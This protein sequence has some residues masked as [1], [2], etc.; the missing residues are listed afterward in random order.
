MALYIGTSGWSY[1]HWDGVLYPPGL[2]PGERFACYLQRFHTV[3]V[4][5]PFYRWPHD[6]TFVRWHRQLPPDF[7]M[8]VKAA[9][10]LTHATRLYAPEKWLSRISQG[11][12]YLGKNRGILLVQLPPDFACDFARLEYFLQCVPPWL[13]VAVEMRHP[14]WHQ[15]PIF[16]LLEQTQTAYCVMSGAHLPCILRATAPFVYVRLHGPD[17]HHLYAGSYSNDSLHWWRDR[18]WDWDRRGCDVFVY[19][20]NDGEG[21]AVRNAETLRGLLGNTAP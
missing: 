18:I 16:Q 7:R 2:P 3:E 14:S 12:R 17:I 11:M 15:E 21:N 10:G 8:T 4:N 6:A 9:R 5:S 13:Q 19:F 20:N 1:A